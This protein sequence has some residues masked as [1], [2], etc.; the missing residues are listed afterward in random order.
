MRSRPRTRGGDHIDEGAGDLVNLG[1]DASAEERGRGEVE[2][3]LLHR[4]IEQHRP[5]LRLP[6]RDAGRDPGI[7]RHQIGLHRAGFERDRQRAPVQAMLLEIEQHQPARKQQAENPAPPERRGE[8]LGLVEQHQFIG[9]GPEHHQAGLAENMAAI[10]QPVFGG[11]PLDLS[12]GVGQYLQRLADQR[13]ALVAGN[14]RERIALRRGEGGG[15]HTLHRHGN[16][17]VGPRHRQ[18]R[19]H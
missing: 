8:L 15:S 19:R 1:T 6:L 18:D 5:R 7:E 4:G 16:G 11:L 9:L 14:M 3:K 17:S 2:G 13:P 10:D 12:L